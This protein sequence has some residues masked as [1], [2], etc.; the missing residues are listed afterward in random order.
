M[1]QLKS[2]WGL[3]SG[4]LEVVSDGNIGS[5]SPFSL[6]LKSF[7]EKNMK[8]EFAISELVQYVKMHVSDISD[9]TPLGNPLRMIGD[10][11]GEFVFRLAG[12]AEENISVEE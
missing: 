9:Q 11:G 3:T 6:V 1:D 7:L 10:D 4:R 5:N 12:R 2:R 8:K